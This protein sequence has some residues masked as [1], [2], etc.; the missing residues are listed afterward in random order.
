MPF[1]NTLEAQMSTK[2]ETDNQTAETSCTIIIRE[3][4][5]TYLNFR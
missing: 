2:D 4:N 3:S 5:I 1:E